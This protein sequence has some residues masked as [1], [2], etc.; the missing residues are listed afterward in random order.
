MKH[1]NILVAIP[2]VIY[3]LL[4]FWFFDNSFVRTLLF[5]IL[6]ISEL[7]VVGVDV[8]IRKKAGGKLAHSISGRGEEP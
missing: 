1:K 2:I 6:C 7:S 5:M 4:T 3:I 8:F